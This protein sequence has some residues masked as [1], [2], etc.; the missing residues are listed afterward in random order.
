[1]RQVGDK[2]HIPVRVNRSRSLSLTL[3]CLLLCCLSRRRSLRR[4]PTLAMCWVHLGVCAS[5]AVE[6]AAQLPRRRVCGLK[7]VSRIFVAR[8][9][10]RGAYRSCLCAVVG[11]CWLLC[12]WT[13]EDRSSSRWCCFED[14]AVTA[15]KV[16]G[17]TPENQA[18]I[19]CD[20]V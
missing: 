18:A 7:A 13:E 3:L 20:T 5:L 4:R 6:E 2:V 1:M 17:P 16:A 10:P 14:L 15:P 19:Y 9:Q 8:K 11:L 12:S